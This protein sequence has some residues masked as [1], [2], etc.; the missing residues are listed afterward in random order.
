[1]EI[2]GSDSLADQ[3]IYDIK[4]VSNNRKRKS[5]D[6]P[7]IENHIVSYGIVIFLADDRTIPEAVELFCSNSVIAIE[8][9]GEIETWN[10][11]L[12]TNMRG[13]FRDKSDFNEDISSW[14]VSKVT[15]MSYMFASASVFNQPLNTWNVS[16]VT[17]MSFMFSN[18]VS[19]DQPLNQWSVYNVTDMSCMFYGAEKFN[20][21]LSRWN[22]GNVKQIGGMFCNASSFSYSL[23]EW[24]LTSA[25]SCERDMIV[26]MFHNANTNIVNNSNRIFN[27]KTIR[28]AV[29]LYCRHAKSAIAKFGEMNKW[30]TSQVTDMSG[31]FEYH[32]E[33]NTNIND[34]D[35]SNVTNMSEMFYCAA[36]FNQHC[37][38][39][40]LV[41]S[42]IWIECLQ[43]QLNLTSL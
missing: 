36:S 14:D 12:V 19:F 6:I 33:F 35:V 28:E 37:I 16:N 34:W 22:I 25:T 39:G 18:A 23:D 27:N 43:M 2:D 15:N 17:D 26:P 7:P 20:Q 40:K 21:P 8:K 11:S 30:N 29:S 42:S 1:M 5:D 3:P 13:L 10:T 4:S 31:L 24:N 38:N 41:M 9:Y 32:N